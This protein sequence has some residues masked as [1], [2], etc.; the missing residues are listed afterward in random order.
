MGDGRIAMCLTCV[1][2]QKKV[3]D[4]DGPTVDAAAS[5]VHKG[6]CTKYLF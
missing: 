3:S 1:S 2:P 6:G 4:L 5:G